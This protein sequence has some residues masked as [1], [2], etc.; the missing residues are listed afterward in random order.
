MCE[1]LL[2]YGYEIK[3]HTFYNILL[4]YINILYHYDLLKH[5]VIT[6]Q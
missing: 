6:I 2:M 4:P 5:Y 1:A 3:I